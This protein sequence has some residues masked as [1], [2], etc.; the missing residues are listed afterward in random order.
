MKN[1][2]RMP[3]VVLC[4]FVT[5]VCNWTPVWAQVAEIINVDAVMGVNWKADC[6][7]CTQVG[8][9]NRNVEISVVPGDI[10]VFRQGSNLRHGV[11]ELNAVE[12]DKIR[13]S[14]EDGNDTQIVEEI[15]R[16]GAGIFFPKIPTTTPVEITRIVVKDNF[17]GSL[18]LQC[19][20]H[21]A[22]MKVT[23]KKD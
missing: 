2:I 9:G 11:M 18:Q 6:D 4:G 15:S 12:A 5:A 21:F 10:I 7:R 17:A 14:G 13:K 19:N 1:S 16:V 3:T 23:L 22:G 8:P 20:V